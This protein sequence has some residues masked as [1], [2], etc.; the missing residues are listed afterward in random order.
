MF[1]AKLYL[2][3]RYLRVEQSF[4]LATI[5]TCQNLHLVVPREGLFLRLGTQIA[6][7]SLNNFFVSQARAMKF[8]AQLGYYSTFRLVY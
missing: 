2:T 5:Q 4:S 3:M 6:P 1:Y 7:C 8:S